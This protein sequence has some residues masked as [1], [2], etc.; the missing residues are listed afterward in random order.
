MVR[1]CADVAP[2]LGGL[3]GILSKLLAFVV[4]LLWGRV[5]VARDYFASFLLL[6]PDQKKPSVLNN[7]KHHMSGKG[8]K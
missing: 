4:V 2:G 5:A 1:F 8:M 6:D 3:F 7:L